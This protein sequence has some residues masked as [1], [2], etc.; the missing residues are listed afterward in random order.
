MAE[1]RDKTDQAKLF[2]LG[3]V[4]LFLELALIRYLAGNIWN[5]GYF[6]N[7]VLTAVFVG[8]GLGFT[9]HHHI[10]DRVS[11]W[12]FHLALFV[13]LG[14]VG[15]VYLEH[16]MVPGFTR[17]R[18]DLSGELFFT[19]TP[20]AATQAS[21]T[22]FIACVLAIV[23]AFALVTQRTAKLFRRFKPLT[24]YTLDIG[25][26][27]TGI[28]A[29]MLMSWLRVPADVW[30]AIAGAVFVAAASDRWTSRWLPVVPAVAMVLVAHAQDGRLLAN[31][32]LTGKLEVSWSPYQKVEYIDTWSDPYRIFVNGV[33][34]QN[35]EPAWRLRRMFYQ[36]VYNERGAGVAPYKN[37][38]I[39]GAGSGNDVATALLNDA[40]HV[41]AVE[42]DPEIA[43]LGEVKNPNRP[44]SDPRVNLVVDDGRAFM[45]RTERRYDLIV[46]ALT[47]SLVKVSS[48]SQLRLENYLFTR[49]SVARAFALLDDGGDI[50]FYNY[51]R[52]PWLREKIEDLIVAATGV[53]PET[54]WEGD[55]F[56]VLRAR[57]GGAPGSARSGLDIPT[58]D[59]PFLYLRARG[60]PTTY[61]WAMGGMSLFVALLMAGLHVSTRKKERYAA[62][63]M[64]LTKV[65]FVVMGIAFLLL[66]TKGVIQ[67]SLLFGTT[68]QNSSLVFL[69]VLVMVLAANWAARTPRLVS[70]DLWWIY[71]LLVGSALVT[72]VFPLRNLLAVHSG[73]ARFIVASL[74]TFS[75]IFFANLMFSLTFRDT[76]V[77]EHV[78]GWNLIGAT[79]GGVLEYASMRLGYNLL[80]AIV[81][82]C[83][84]IVFGL[85]LAAARLR[86][87]REARAAS[88][89][90][91]A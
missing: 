45:T 25:G 69:A 12:L 28:A 37:V 88:V 42:I 50:V 31:P 4:T 71:A 30:F 60:I 52:Q 47:D 87:R 10:S 83:Y 1:D 21:A 89:G 46:F 5:L 34:H 23:L 76:E 8:M 77:A 85:L 64:L 57:K 63:G 91:A 9:F 38:L 58:D 17:W 7:L 26:S 43:R 13:L 75:P 2:L 36:T 6:P 82:V 54:V 27:V 39:L 48:M 74:M 62:P 65:A 19:A 14:L 68:W 53:A 80:A 59:W 56:A 16:P 44:F 29:F 51:Y 86:R 55:D 49:E 84:T 67:F 15:F 90:A 32:K 22:P 3:F 33:S 79:I 20:E 70:K 81:A 35:M 78:F 40:D 73:P 66:E 41:D 24:A 11:P 72:L 61:R 18:G